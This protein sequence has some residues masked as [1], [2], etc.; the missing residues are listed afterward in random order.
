VSVSC[1]FGF[2]LNVT[3]RSYGLRRQPRGSSWPL[4]INAI[5]HRCAPPFEV[6]DLGAKK[7]NA[8]VGGRQVWEQTGERRFAGPLFCRD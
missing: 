1:I 4:I 3:G 8:D 5:A 7:S 2:V 6:G